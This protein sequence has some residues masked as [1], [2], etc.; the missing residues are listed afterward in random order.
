MNKGIKYLFAFAVGAAAGS[1]AT[2]K[3]LQ[4]KYQK[5]ADE[6]IAS[7]KDFYER[8]YTENTEE[9]KDENPDSEDEDDSEYFVYEDMA[10]KYST[11]SSDEEKGGSEVAEEKSPYVI[12]PGEFGNGE[13]ELE[14]LLY[15]EKDKV[16]TDDGYT[17]IGK[18]ESLVPPDFASHF[19]DYDYDQDS[20]YV[21]NDRLKTDYEILRDERN[22]N[23]VVKQNPNLTD[24]E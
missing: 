13:H 6:E 12:A 1:F 17:P 10:G 20:V 8:R 5:I 3:L 2:W 22:Y 21:R 4:A 11:E 18:P 15:F 14:T 23:D 9:A 24:E 19:G 16:L 7:M